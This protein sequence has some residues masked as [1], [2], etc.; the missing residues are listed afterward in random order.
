VSGMRGA[1]RH[2]GLKGILLAKYFA[3]STKTINFVA[4]KRNYYYSL[5]H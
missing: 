1:L 2:K 5:R 3:A 4:A